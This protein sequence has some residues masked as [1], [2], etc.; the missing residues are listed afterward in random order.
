M[1]N[2]KWKPW[3]Q[4]VDLRDDLRTGELSLAIFA[5]DLYEVAMQQGRRPI[6]EDPA[7]FFALTYPTYNLRELAR[8]VVLR[9]AGK[10][11]RA[12]RQ[13]ELTYGGGKTH[14]LITLFHL[15]NDP[16]LLPD[17]PAVQEFIQH[18]GVQPPKAQ[19]VILPFD[20]L[21][22]EKGMEVRGPDG[23]LRWLK[24]PWSVMAFQIAGADGL[25]VLHAKGEDDERESAPAENLLLE[26]LRI[27][28]EQG[29]SLLILIDEVLMYTREKVGL[30]PEWRGRLINFFQYLT[31]AVTKVDAC[32]MVASLLATDPRKSDKLGKELT[33]ELYA[34]FRREREEG[35]QPVLKEDVAEVLRRRFF[36]PE[37]IKDRATFRPHVLAALKGITALDEQ[38][39]KE[40]KA[41]EARFLQSYPFHPDLTEI[42]YTKWTNLEGFQRTRGVLR[43][44]ALALRDAEQWD[45]A[46]LVGANV[47][48]TAPGTAGLSEAARELTGIAETEDYEG[49]R[50]EWSAIL[51][52]ELEK[53][54][55]IQ[56][57]E[58]LLHREAERAVL[59]TFLHSQPI[60]QKALTRELLVLLGQ[61]RP[62]KI[63]LEKA[64]RRWTE[65]S[66]FL[67]EDVLQ[68][69][70][71]AAEADVLPRAWRLGSRP[72]LTQMHHDACQ[73][74]VS[75]ELTDAKLLEEI[76]RLNSLT[77]GAKGAGVKVHN[78]SKSPSQVADDGE[79]HYV[80]LPLAAACDPG[81]PSELAQR[82]WTE[83]TSPEKP[84]V[85]KNALV[86]VAPSP[87]GLEQARQ[88]VL[89]YLGW[90]EVQA[91]LKKQDL[92]KC[93]PL[94]WQMLLAKLNAAQKAIPGAIRQAYTTVI[95][96]SEKGEVEA[97]KV[98]VGSEPLFAII[99]AD[100]HTRIQETAISAEA[101]LPGG[102][103]ELWQAGE[104]SRWLKDLVGAFAQHPHLPKMLNR[105][106]I[107]DT[108]VQGCVEGTFVF[109]L[110]RPDGSL[111]TS[112]R[113][114][115]ED[116]LLKE[117]G[118]EV[119]LPEAATLSKLSSALL[120][121]G[122]LPGLWERKEDAFGEITQQAVYDY[123]AGAHVVQIQ[124]DGYEEPVVI[125]EAPHEVVDEA[126]KSAV[127]GGELWLLSGPASIWSEEIPAGVLSSDA[128]LLPPPEAISPTDLL[129]PNLPEA[130][131]NEVTTAL[132]IVAALSKRAGE[133][134]PWPLVR[135]AL[136]AAFNYNYL[137]RTL[138]SGPWPCE[139]PGAQNVK[140]RIPTEPPEP[141]TTPP[142]G[143]RVA[144]A[145]L[146]THEL[147]DLA[148]NM[149]DLGKATAG[150]DM[151][152]RVCIELSGDP[153]DEVVEEA[154]EVMAKA[155]NTLQFK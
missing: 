18:I 130:W 120:I 51:L 76:E 79:F 28:E 21:D 66:W 73:N 12:I 154:N 50:Q 7:E 59:A 100:A 137:T 34:I 24:H 153:S 93:D 152:L 36:T 82:F 23:E 108:L 127:E 25:R 129:Q 10:S 113:H 29:L 112:W 27:P 117:P 147:Q 99:K 124:K 115:P 13:L 125:P 65:V 52:G 15:V 69:G 140:V 67:D 87:S 3:H 145:E 146:E 135:R 78:L 68:E 22:V 72:N 133:N 83:T 150:C 132:A 77:S 114:Q 111:Y 106:A 62:D 9:L 71:Q 31:Q 57:Q 46:P 19:V 75:L 14:A 43:T 88:A 109:R 37:S 116:A 128:R 142:P 134:L 110:Q 155:S 122:E 81:N 2:L 138:D 42:L 74:R 47:F 94:R 8:G 86:L 61:T 48:L 136:D 92:A 119:V 80:V 54:Q 95:T 6:Y 38:T 17:L 107:L 55:E 139:Y 58:A 141:P 89:A 70:V 39:A 16:A 1:G 45:M 98:R 143:V 91:Q 64:L 5:A 40:G 63:T 121:P 96:L 33:Q 41:A 85:N 90:Q 123:F 44:F 118:M 101:L 30:Q 11:D 151:K 103:Y 49:K 56:Q 144:E 35:V 26:L 126:V 20:K 84:R 102:P 148:D 97:F 32:A 131:P 149:G 105:Q 60:G 104:T 53:V 4:V